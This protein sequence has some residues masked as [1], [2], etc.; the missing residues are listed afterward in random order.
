[1]KRTVHLA[2]HALLKPG[3]APDVSFVP[4][5]VRRRFSPLQK[6]YFALAKTAEKT[7]AANA[8]F[9]SRDGEDTLTRR[10]VD[11]FHA[12]GT[13]S[14]HRFSA[15]VYNASPGLWSV[16]T[17]NRSPY[18]AVA[19]GDDSPECG[20]LEALSGPMPALMVYAEETDGGYGA[21][22]FFEDVPHARSVV[23][24]EGDPARGAVTFGALAAFLSGE[25]HVLEGRWLTLKDASCAG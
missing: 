6:L 15:S 8:V 17:K 10:L 21:A 24:S 13:V 22:M 19:A 23:I 7:P 14:P 12:D 18:T 5:L 4:P 25:T 16:F 20:I 1:M 2:A 11:E 3:E 9:S